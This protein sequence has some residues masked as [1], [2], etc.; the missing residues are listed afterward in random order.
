MPVYAELLD[1][2]FKENKEE[3]FLAQTKTDTTTKSSGSSEASSSGKNENI[4]SMFPANM[5]TAGKDIGNVKYANNG[6]LSSDNTENETSNEQSGETHTTTL[7]GSMLDSIIKFNREYKNI[8]N[9]LL[10][11]FNGLFSYILF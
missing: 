5:A 10:N 7:S 4:A 1:L 8:F 11:E 6:A 9:K 2:F 3:I